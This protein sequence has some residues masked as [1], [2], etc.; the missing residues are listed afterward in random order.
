[1]KPEEK[2]KLLELNL[3]ELLKPCPFC[4][5]TVGIKFTDTEEKIK[6]FSCGVQIVRSKG[7]GVALAWNNRI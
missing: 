1:M 4:G 3:G 7:V 6:C 5:A 2:I